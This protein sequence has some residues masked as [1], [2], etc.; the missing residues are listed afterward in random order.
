MNQVIPKR[1]GQKKIAHTNA[2]KIRLLYLI[3]ANAIRDALVFTMLF[4][5]RH[6]F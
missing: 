5:A 4:H 2:R 3:N 6:F 1:E